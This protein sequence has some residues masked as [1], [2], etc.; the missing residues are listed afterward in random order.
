MG[1]SDVA[2]V[3]LSFVVFFAWIGCSF[4]IGSYAT[5]K[6]RSFGG[7]FGISLLISPIIA[8]FV[9]MFAQ[10]EAGDENTGKYRK[11][12]QCAETVRTEAKICR[13]C[14]SELS[15]AVPVRE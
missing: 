12:P 3:I 4:A 11:C 7:W 5:G 15:E 2:L 13:H 1:G 10:P 6:G 14:H 9:L 8:Y